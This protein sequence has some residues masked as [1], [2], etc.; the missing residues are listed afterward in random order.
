MKNSRQ[1]TKNIFVSSFLLVAYLFLGFSAHAQEEK[2]TLYNFAYSYPQIL[3]NGTSSGYPKVVY[4]S[5]VVKCEF[6]EDE[7]SMDDYNNLDQVWE[8]KVEAN[9][10]V[11]DM[12]MVTDAWLWRDRGEVEEERNEQ[13]IWFKEKG[14]RVYQRY[15]FSFYYECSSF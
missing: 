3:I 7:F 2:V 12:I 13:I 14:Y 5:P 9:F 1:T 8:Q 4:V 10:P 11:E 6:N 15:H